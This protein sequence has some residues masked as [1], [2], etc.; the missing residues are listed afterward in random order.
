MKLGRFGKFLARQFYKA[1]LILPELAKENYV[2]SILEKWGE[3]TAKLGRDLLD[4]EKADLA[5]EV[6]RHKLLG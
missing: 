1:K 2:M 6:I 4:E 3:V 5:F